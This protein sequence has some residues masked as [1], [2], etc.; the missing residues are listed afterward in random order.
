METFGSRLKS[1]RIK[2]GLTQKDVAAIFKITER[3]YQN[4]E[5]DKSTPNF[6]LLV[7]IANLFDISIDYLAGRTNNPSAHK[8]INKVLK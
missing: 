8:P 6:S 1:A 4:Y 2:K 5:I 3:A 7:D